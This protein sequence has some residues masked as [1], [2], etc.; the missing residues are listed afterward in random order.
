MKLRG[1][2]KEMELDLGGVGVT[3]IKITV[4]HS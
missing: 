1:G 4:K 2:G 3:V